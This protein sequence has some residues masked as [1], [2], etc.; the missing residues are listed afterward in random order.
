MGSKNNPQNRGKK[1]IKEYNGEQ[2]VPAMFINS[3]A[4]RKNN[5]EDSNNSSGGGA[6]RLIVAQFA[7]SRKLVLDANNNPIAWDAI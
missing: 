4:S 3:A 6:G 2:I 7:K 1:Q 5:N